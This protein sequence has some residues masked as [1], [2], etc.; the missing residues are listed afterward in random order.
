MII[1]INIFYLL[2]LIL[3]LPF[4]FSQYDSH[5]RCVGGSAPAHK[6]RK[7]CMDCLL[8]SHSSKCNCSL[9]LQSLHMTA[10]G[11]CL[12]WNPVTGFQNNKIMLR[13]HAVVCI[14]T[15]FTGYTCVFT[16]FCY[17]KFSIILLLNWMCPLWHR[18]SP[19]CYFIYVLLQRLETNW[20]LC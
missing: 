17:W 3:P 14:K 6:M 8:F 13:T 2:V 4:G 20:G 12:F 1:S 7:M 18:L 9:N 15:W 19:V 11:N 5:I 10:P 16:T